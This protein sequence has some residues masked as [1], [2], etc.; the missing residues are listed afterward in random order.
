[1]Q[2]A[3]DGTRAALSLFTKPGMYNAEV[4][5]KGNLVKYFGVPGLKEVKEYEVLTPGEGV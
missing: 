2:L 3:W 1:M 4:L 5:L